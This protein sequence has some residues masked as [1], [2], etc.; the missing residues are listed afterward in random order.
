LSIR[1]IFDKFARRQPFAA[2]FKNCQKRLENLVVS[3][4][5]FLSNL[6]NARLILNMD[7]YAAAGVINRNGNQL[8]SSRSSRGGRESLDLV[9]F[10]NLASQNVPNSVGY[11]VASSRVRLQQTRSSGRHRE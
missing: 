7:C 3:R 6:E 10:D 2:G 8:R 5:R 11:A 4:D 1:I 9:L